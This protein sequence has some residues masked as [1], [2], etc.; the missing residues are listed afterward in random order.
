MYCHQI[1]NTIERTFGIGNGES[2]SI[3]FLASPHKHRLHGG[4]ARINYLAHT[5]RQADL[6]PQFYWIYPAVAMAHLHFREQHVRYRDPRPMEKS[7]VFQAYVHVKTAI[8][9]ILS[10]YREVT[11]RR[12]YAVQPHHHDKQE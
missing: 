8:V 5:T 2:I 1:E 10:I 12:K 7:C 6:K 9:I 4:P 11:L 3:L